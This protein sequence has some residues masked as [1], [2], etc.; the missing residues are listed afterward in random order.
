[1]F[2]VDIF[3]E[4]YRGMTRQEQT[5]WLK[6]TEDYTDLM[7]GCPRSAGAVVLPAGGFAWLLHEYKA[8]ERSLQH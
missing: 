7:A 8:E 4:R 2:E 5:A 1:M 3:A 6:E